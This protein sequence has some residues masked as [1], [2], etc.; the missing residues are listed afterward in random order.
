MD[1]PVAGRLQLWIVSRMG[2][3]DQPECKSPAPRPGPAVAVD[4]VH[5]VSGGRTEDRPRRRGQD[6]PRDGQ[7][8][9]GIAGRQ[10]A[11]IDDGDQTALRHDEI[12]R[13]EIAMDP[14]RWPRPRRH[15]HTR[16]PNLEDANGVDTVPELLDTLE[17]GGCPFH[18]RDAPVS[19]A[20]SLRRRRFVK[21]SEKPPQIFG[22]RHFVDR[23]PG[24][25]VA[26]EPRHDAPR[27]WVA[28][29]GAT[30]S[31][32]DGNG[33]RQTPGQQWEPLLLMANEV[34]RDAPSRQADKQAVTQSIQLVVPP[35]AD[36]L[37]RKM[38]Q[39]RMLLVQQ[40]TNKR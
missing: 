9:C 38:C 20:G 40:R 12:A 25:C 7:I 35:G 26:L 15:T 31:E 36:L 29:A 21:R 23:Y 33:Q 8:R 18:Q 30:R 11:E 16:V 1:Q 24:D 10:V 19:V 6:R 28:A 22:H 39:V 32:W 37:E 17:Y 4:R 5:G 3:I 27:P 34:R 14:Q 13:M 2:E